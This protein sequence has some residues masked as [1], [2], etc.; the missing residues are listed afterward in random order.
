VHSSG[1]QTGGNDAFAAH[2]DARLGER[3]HRLWNTLDVVPHTWSEAGL[4]RIP[5]L[6]EGHSAPGLLVSWLCA[7]AA[8]RASRVGYAH[9]ESGARAFTGAISPANPG[10]TL[11]MMYQHG[12]AYVEHLGLSGVLTLRDMTGG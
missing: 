6:Y 5:S 8:R 7:W 4:R 12:L 10:F 1:A 2:A 11:Q 9:P 3:H